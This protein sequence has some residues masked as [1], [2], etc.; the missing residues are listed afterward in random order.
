MD[1]VNGVIDGLSTLF[2]IRVPILEA[3]NLLPVRM[4]FSFKIRVCPQVDERPRFHGLPV[5]SQGVH[6]CMQIPRS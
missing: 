1:S 4:P 6:Q 3:P 2:P 5:P